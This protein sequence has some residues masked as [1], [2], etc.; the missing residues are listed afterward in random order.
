MLREHLVCVVVLSALNAL[1]LL[2]QSLLT[3]L[4]TALLTALL[5][6]LLRPPRLLLHRA[7]R[8][9]RTAAQRTDNI[10]KL[11]LDANVFIVKLVSAVAQNKINATAKNLY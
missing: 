8:R 7:A 1:L 2:H 5:I 3:S 9:S 4:L 6:A 10:I 11:S